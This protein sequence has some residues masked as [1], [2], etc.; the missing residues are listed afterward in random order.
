MKTY[1]VKYQADNKNDEMTMEAASESDAME[2]AVKRFNDMELRNAC[3][4]DVKEQTE[5]KE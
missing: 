3:I 5:E 2:K 4:T 1:K